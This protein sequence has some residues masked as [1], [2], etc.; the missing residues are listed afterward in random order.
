MF[1]VVI[2]LYNKAHTIERTLQSVLNQTYTNFE[3]IIV[4]DGST[5]NGVQLIEE[6]FQDN[7]LTIVNQENQGVAIARNQGVSLANYKY[8]AFLDGDDTWEPEYL[9]TAKTAI[10]RFPNVG[11]YC[12]AG[13]YSEREGEVLAVRLARKYKG[14][15]LKINYFENPHVFSH[16]SATVIAVAAFENLGGFQKNMKKNEDFALFFALALTNEVVYI[17][18]PLSTYFGF[19]EG[20]ITSLKDKDYCNVKETINRMNYTYHIWR[21]TPEPKNT[22]FLVFLKYEIRHYILMGIINKD[23][24]LVTHFFKLLDKGIIAMFSAFELNLYFKKNF[25][26]LKI[27]YIYISKLFWRMNGFPRVG[28]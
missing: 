17:G 26:I 14:Q 8:I 27:S 16:T 25:S 15:L 12:F 1:S 7:R 10:T 18:I 6:N 3:I 24:M 22:L 20:Q 28:G 21:Q 5:D 19:V 11:M 2:P 23:H 4:D 13:Y 9:E